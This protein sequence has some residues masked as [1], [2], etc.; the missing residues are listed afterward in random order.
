MLNT[1]PLL[2]LLLLVQVMQSQR[3]IEGADADR[4]VRL[5]V[6][7]L[8]AGLAASCCITRQSLSPTCV[9]SG[10][11]ENVTRRKFEAV[12]EWTG[13]DGDEM[14]RGCITMRLNITQHINSCTG[15]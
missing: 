3:T 11:E 8:A 5:S 4:G 10:E 2:L 9:G 13:D 15:R 7:T 1:G 12:T 14:E 6:C